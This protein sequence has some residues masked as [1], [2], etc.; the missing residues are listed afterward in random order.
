MATASVN[1]ALDIYAE[2]YINTSS[3]FLEKRDTSHRK[4]HWISWCMIE[5]QNDAFNVYEKKYP[6]FDIKCK[7]YLKYFK[8]IFYLRFDRSQIDKC[9]I[10]QLTVK[11][12]E[13]NLS[14]NPKRLFVAELM[15]RKGWAEKF[16]DKISSIQD[17]CMKQEDIVTITFDFMQNLLLP[18]DIQSICYLRQ[19]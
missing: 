18:H 4:G 15:I 17:L 6:D 1:I 19:L 9:K 7:F 13:S 14:E 5:C 16:Y 10:C 2:K 3:A 8:K 12:K 11:I